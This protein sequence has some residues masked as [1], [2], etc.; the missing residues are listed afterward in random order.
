MSFQKEKSEIIDWARRLNQK[1]LV[2]AKSGNISYK[3]DD[4][5][6]LITA[7]DSYLGYLE[8]EDI[9]LADLK[10][11]NSQNSGKGTSEQLMHLSI[12][13]KFED[14]K[15]ILHAHSPFTTAFFHYF[16]ELETFSYETKFYLGKIT[17]LEQ[18]TPTVTEIEPLLSALEKSNIVVLKHHGVVAMGK[19][20]KEAFSLIE[21]LEEQAKVNLLVKGKFQITNSK[22]QT[23]DNYQNPNIQNESVKKQDVKKYKMLSAEHAQRLTDLVNSDSQ[24]QELGQKYG[25]TCDLAVKNQENGE[26]MR[27]CYEKGKIIKTDTSEEADFVIIG[28]EDILKK[29]FNKE[30]DPFVASTQGKVK[31]KGDF[32]KM[33]RWYPVMVRTFKLWEQAPVE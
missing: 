1:G 26:V 11:D 4:K 18:N 28:K 2:T 30:I 9:L 12:Y 15:V 17:A 20:F 31:T 24:A 32:A 27:F 13:N 10:G 23:N 6:I 14:N 19:D 25:L 33:S 21:L 29:V 16:K 22:L 7:H 3:L 5:K 8:D